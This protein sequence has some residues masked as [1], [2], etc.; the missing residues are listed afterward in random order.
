M[1]LPVV[2]LVS[3][4]AYMAARSLC[5]CVQAR[6]LVHLQGNV[7]LSCGFDINSPV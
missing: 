4:A 1:V 3:Y 2:G 5:V 7:C 6:A